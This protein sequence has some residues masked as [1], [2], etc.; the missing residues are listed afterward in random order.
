[1]GMGWGRSGRGVSRTRASRARRTA[2]R[3]G[4][5]GSFLGHHDVWAEGE[6][7]F[8][9]PCSA[10]CALLRLWTA[11]QG[12]GGGGRERPRAR[13]DGRVHTSLCQLCDRARP[14]GLQLRQGRAKHTLAL[15]VGLRAFFPH[16]AAGR[17]VFA[18]ADG[19]LFR[20]QGRLDLGAEEEVHL[21]LEVGLERYA[22]SCIFRFERLEPEDC[23][24]ARDA[25]AELGGQRADGVLGRITGMKPPELVLDDL[26]EWCRWAEGVVQREWSFADPVRALGCGR[27]LVAR[28]NG[29]LDPLLEGHDE[30]GSASRSISSAS[31]SSSPSSSA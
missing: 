13:R 27:L 22:M 14:P 30:S 11:G 10:R 31:S 15:G 29:A 18:L 12:G 20:V 26:V 5:A 4:R 28:S 8:G 23:L 21:G 6:R 19:W 7:R 9:T 1:M 16:L 24:Y 17:V 2:E 25:D 3:S